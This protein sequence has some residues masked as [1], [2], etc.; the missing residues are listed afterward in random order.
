MELASLMVNC[1]IL[2][3]P[4]MVVQNSCR[5]LREAI[6]LN[7]ID[8]MGMDL[9]LIMIISPLLIPENASDDMDLLFIFFSSFVERFY[10]LVVI[11]QSRFLW[12]KD[13]LEILQS[14]F[15]PEFRF[16]VDNEVKYRTV[17][18]ILSF[19]VSSPRLNILIS[20]LI[21]ELI[22]TKV[23]SALDII[24]KYPNLFT[25]QRLWILEYLR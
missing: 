25:P 17:H 5:K 19:S 8:S 4:D 14:C 15:G 21:L 18:T 24:E 9:E 6:S 16:V 7:S 3:I 23:Y 2:L 20:A 10:E 13:V 22:E 11:F 1:K 12:L